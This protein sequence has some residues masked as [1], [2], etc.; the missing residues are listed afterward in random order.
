MKSPRS[1]P[2]RADRFPVLRDELARLSGSFG[3]GVIEL[4]LEN[5]QKSQVLFPA[6]ATGMAP[7]SSQ[8]R[9][10]TFGNS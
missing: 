7:T 1:A 3:I 8:R 5:A 10:R 6:R 9:T 2:K 4:D